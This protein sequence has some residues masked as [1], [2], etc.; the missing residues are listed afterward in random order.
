MFPNLMGQKAFHKLTD[1]DMGQIIGVS[2]Q[3][4]QSKMQSGRFTPRECRTLCDYF[5]KDFD[6]LF[7]V[8]ADPAPVNH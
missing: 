6:F 4:F 7:A 5:G 8:E 1:A 2:R 3:T